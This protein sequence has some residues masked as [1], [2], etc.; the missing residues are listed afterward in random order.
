MRRAILTFVIVT[1]IACPAMAVFAWAASAHAQEFFPDYDGPKYQLES[2]EENVLKIYNLF[3]SGATNDSCHPDQFGGRVAK[4][5]FDESGLIITGAV[6]EFDDG[7]RQFVNIEVDTEVMAPI[8][9]GWVVPGLQK[10]FKEGRDV[11]LKLY[12]CGAAGRVLY[13]DAVW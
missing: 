8:Q 6:L 12:R 13:V 9:T 4:R 10:L 5:K 1:M 11:S 7:T 2:K 3:P